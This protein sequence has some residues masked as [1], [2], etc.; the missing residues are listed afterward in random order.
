MVPR[1]VVLAL[2]VLLTTAGF[3]GV[4]LGAIPDNRVTIT[5][6]AVT[7]DPP[8]VDAPITV[9][10][11]VRLSAGSASA[12][13][14]ERVAVLDESG[15]LLGEANGLGALSPGETLTVPVTVRFAAPGEQA[16][17]VVATV[18]D[19]DDET[20][21]ASRPVSLVVEAG[22]P[23]VDLRADRLVAGT[24]SAATVTVSNPTTAPL[25]DLTVSLLDVDGERTQRTI[26]SLGA[27]ASQS[28]NVSLRP[29]QQGERTLAVDV[30][31]T[32]VTGTRVTVTEERTV[33]VAALDDD[34]GVRVE[35]TMP[36]QQSM[37][38]GGGGGLSGLAGAL[39]GSGLLQPAA[40]GSDGDSGQA[41][42]GAAIT[43]TNFGNAPIETVVLVPQLPDGTLAP[44]LG[45]VAVTDALAPGDS[46]QVTVDLSAVTAP[47]LRFAVQYEL[48]GEAREVVRPYDLDRSRG[49]VALTGVNLDVEGDRVRL[50]GNL[51]NV[52]DGDVRG[53]IVR[54]G[55]SESVEP[56]YPQ[57]SYFLGTIADSEF[58]PFELTA[59]VDPA[60]ATTVPVEVSY[61]TGGERLTETIE[62]PLPPAIEEPKRRG[63]L[64]GAGAAGGLGGLLAGAGIALLVVVTLAGPRVRRSR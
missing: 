22:T 11:T 60:N 13:T 63:I 30:T 56:A 62:L 2:V 57:R 64:G 36:G 43:V 20:T 33:F 61:T 7:P 21:T 55:T 19:V 1:S 37:T 41:Q 46:A 14:V 53:V 59:Q 29:E 58:A 35:R 26:A 54:V 24:D 8:T 48:A 17:T 23:Q 6:T 52:G 5:A 44:Q 51:G 4:S 50:T 34:V 27:G 39:G 16:L 3:A 49:A 45:R 40:S 32:T 18:A 15:D 25:R 42:A 38:A 47:S 31:Y 12:A 28:L 9:S 10:A